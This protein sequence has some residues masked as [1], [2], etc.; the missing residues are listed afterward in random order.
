MSFLLRNII[1]IVTDQGEIVIETNDPDVEVE[2]LKDGKTFRVV[3]TKTNQSF[4]IRSGSYEIRAKANTANSQGDQNVAFDVTP[5]RLIMKR[6]QQ[7]IVTVTK[8]TKAPGN[9]EPGYDPKILPKKTV[10]D[11]PKPVFYPI[12]NDLKVTVELVRTA[13]AGSGALVTL[14]EDPG[15]IVV[16]GNKKDHEVVFVALASDHSLTYG[17]KNFDQ[18]MK[19]ARTD[20]SAKNFIDAIRACGDLAK[21]DS[22]RKELFAVIGGVARR[23]GIRRIGEKTIDEAYGPGTVF[24]ES[25]PPTTVTSAMLKAVWTQPPELAVEFVKGELEIGNSRSLT[26]CYWII[27]GGFGSSKAPDIDK[28]DHAL[29]SHLREL[30]P[31]AVRRNRLTNTLV[32]WA[33]TIP[34]K[35]LVELDPNLDSLVDKLILEETRI[36]NSTLV[37]PLNTLFVHLRTDDVEIIWPNIDEV[38][39]AIEGANDGSTVMEQR[40]QAYGNFSS[41]KIQKQIEAMKK[42]AGS[43]KV[44]NPLV[45]NGQNFQQWLEI[46]KTDRSPKIVANAIRACGAL[47]ETE[48]EVKELFEVMS[49]AARRHG[50]AVVDGGID[51]EVMSVM[52][53][54]IWNQ[55]PERAVDFVKEQLKNG[56][57][58]SLQFCTWILVG[59]FNNSTTPDIEKLDQAF[60]SRLFELL[61]L[62]AKRDKLV[63]SLVGAAF[64]V[65]RKRLLELNPE[66]QSLVVKLFW[67]QTK[68]ADSQSLVSLVTLAAYLRIDDAKIVEH[69]ANYCVKHAKEPNGIFDPYFQALT[70]VET[71]R[72]KRGNP[73][74][75][76]PI[77]G[78]HDE[79]RF[80]ALLELLVA[81]LSDDAVRRKGLDKPNG[82]FNV[83]SARRQFLMVYQLQEC[84]HAILPKMDNESRQ[85]AKQ[86]LLAAKRDLPAIF[87]SS[88]G[89]ELD[90]EKLDIENNLDALIAACDGKSKPEF[91]KVGQ[92]KGS[93]NN[94]DFGGGYGGGGVF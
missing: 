27:I 20:L 19:V 91:I 25:F 17:G 41:E 64:S 34:R 46:A 49:G 81:E 29:A 75:F 85:K 21:T 55:P 86:A 5:N 54:A 92:A 22:Q 31:L 43:P 40:Q 71:Q 69:L 37:A 7:Q 63:G 56:N 52:L 65:S 57:S 50:N 79:I 42:E 84:L 10:V 48:P 30:L 24:V 83:I 61:P 36:E 47:A 1:R 59:G 87:K 68:L 80:P 60:A 74:S 73:K 77:V 72:D 9:A 45:Y 28:L 51:D 11:Q 18:W 14:A 88:E 26:F 8:T 70:N 15:G 62:A 89:Q 16:V 58:R 35:Q 39:Q 44:V 76:Q 32:S 90:I 82:P 94:Q 3:D 6:G 13:L 12:K 93:P 38:P 53:K 78:W 4:D 23:D 67:E 2:F 66:L 33:V